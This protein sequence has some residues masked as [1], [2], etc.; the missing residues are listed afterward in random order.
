MNNGDKSA[1]PLR[2][3]D[4]GLFNYGDGYIEQC[5]DKLAI[6][7]TKREHF[8]AMA[9]QGFCSTFKSGASIISAYK[10]DCAELSVAY[11]DALLKALE[12]ED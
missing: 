1:Q 2:G 11:A 5:G 9:M 4:N 3:C 7:L 10:D 6:G 12:D 8:A